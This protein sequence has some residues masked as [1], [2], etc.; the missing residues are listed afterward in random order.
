MARASSSHTRRFCALSRKLFLVLAVLSICSVR[1]LAHSHSH[2]HVHH[3][4]SHAHHSCDQPHRHSRAEKSS[5][6]DAASHDHDR[7][8]AHAQELLLSLPI[9][10]LASYLTVT[11]RPL[12]HLAPEPAA[13]TASLLTSSVSLVSVLLLP[14][15]AALSTL[16][17]PFAVG[18][19]LS[20]LCTH[21]LPH[22]YADKAPIT[23]LLLGVA[24]FALLDAFLERFTHHHHIHPEQTV[25]ISQSQATQNIQHHPAHTTNARKDA[26]INLAADALHNFCDGLSI[27][28]AFMV[29]P[30]AGIAT[31]IAVIL[32]ELPQELADFAVLLRAGFSRSFALFTNFVCACT[33]LLG[34]MAALRLR[35]FAAN[36]DA[37]VL[38]FAAGALLYMTFCTVL[39]HVVQD[40]SKPAYA[41]GKQVPV[42]F[43]RFCFRALV[44][45]VSA[46][47]GVLLVALVEQTHEH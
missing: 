8:H 21:L 45:F 16:L 25:T 36:A 32:H 29:S 47:S 37:I 35:T 31:T 24:L 14:F 41:D 2:P 43:W 42:P 27:A 30:S 13:Y 26:Y 23:P 11:L 38:P 5:H 19:L 28:A 7:S 6:C 22:I 40:I 1:A 3:S 18:A 15:S 17:L 39:P 9:D 4:H 46:A 44:A 10:I 34:T 33:A 20:D 12:R